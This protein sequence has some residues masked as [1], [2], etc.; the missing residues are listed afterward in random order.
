MT[1]RKKYLSS[2]AVLA[3]ASALA[4]VGVSAQTGSS[5]D[6]SGGA[7]G[8]ASSAG[9]LQR[10]DQGMLRDI[11]EA[12]LAEIATGKLALEKAQSAQVKKFAQ[13]MVDDHATALKEVQQVAQAKGVS[14]PDEP[15]LKHKTIAKA[16][17]T[18]DGER[19]DKQYISQVGVG[20]HRQTR[21]LL[22]KTRTNAKDADVKAL[23][24]KMLPVVEGHLAHAEQ[25][26]GK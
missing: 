17:Q 22:Q 25:M 6:R 9:Q 23:A 5:T 13:T 10:S 2:V 8:K 1:Q 26:T 12:N 15:G 14:L 7:S 20:D 19:F 3:V 21:E 16:L 18:M 4:T 24:T 11:A